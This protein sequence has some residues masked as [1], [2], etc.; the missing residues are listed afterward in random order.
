M[1]FRLRTQPIE[2]EPGSSGGGKRFCRSLPSVLEVKVINFKVF[3]FCFSFIFFSSFFN[4]YAEKKKLVIYTYDSFVS[5]WGP[6][7]QIK[8]SFEEICDCIVDFVGFSNSLDIIGRIKLEDT[9]SAADIIL[10]LDT[11][12]MFELE[13]LNLVRNH[14]VDL[15]N[16]DLPV[17]WDNKSFVPYDWGHFSFIFDENKVKNAPETFREIFENKNNTIIIQDPRTSTVG[18]GLL[19]WIKSIYGEK[20]NEVW[21]KLSKNILTVTSGWTEAY[22]MF[23]DGQSDYVLSYSTSPAY[24]IMVEGKNNYK[25]AVF[26]E[27]HYL[28][29]EVMA[30]TKTTKNYELSNKFLEF[31]LEEKIQSLIPTTNWM[32]P[33]TKVVLPET[34]SNLKLPKK[35]FLID[36]GKV[37]K[38]RKKWLNEWL[39]ESGF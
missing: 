23:L 13:S 39:L 30:I 25:A 18:L 37:F 10:G 14:L 4:A 34:F 38:N 2:P 20:S 16:L 11:N 29:I 8:N 27:G 35:V 1:L 28:Q 32:F 19:L 17:K 21:Q 7:P 24:H 6:A 3:F 15:S 26:Q 31:I 5:E 22:G 12:Q 36:S 9:N 33:A